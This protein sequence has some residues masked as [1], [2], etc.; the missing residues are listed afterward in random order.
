M[1]RFALGT[2][3]VNME[4]NGY[5]KGLV[6]NRELTVGEARH[7]MRDLLGIDIQT[8][9]DFDFSYDYTEFNNNLRLD[10]T[11]WLRGNLEDEVIMQY[12]YDCSDDPIGIMN[13]I[14]IILYLKKRKI[15]D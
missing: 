4:D 11:D 15:I 13:L 14:P 1:K 9:D 2:I 6:L 5:V 3:K 12:A 8:R 10:V 7:I